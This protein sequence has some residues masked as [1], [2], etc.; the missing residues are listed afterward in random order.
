M[1]HE[2]KKKNSKKEINCPDIQQHNMT[3]TNRHRESNLTVF[4][5]CYM[6]IEV[7]TTSPIQYYGNSNDMPNLKI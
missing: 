7:G 1:V 4:P 3:N 5:V 6:L 2:R